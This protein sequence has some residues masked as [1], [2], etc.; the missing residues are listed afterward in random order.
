MID[1]KSPDYREYEVYYLLNFCLLPPVEQLDYFYIK[2]FAPVTLQEHHLG[3][4]IDS[5][6]N[7]KIINPIYQLY[8]SGVYYSGEFISLIWDL[9]GGWSDLY[10]EM[11]VLW[12]ELFAS[13]FRGA[14]FS[15]LERNTSIKGFIGGSHWPEI[16][17]RAKLLLKKADFLDDG[18]VY[19]KPMK[20]VGFH[21]PDDFQ[22][23][24]PYPYWSTCGEFM[25]RADWNRIRDQVFKSYR[26]AEFNFD[27][28]GISLDSMP[29]T[30]A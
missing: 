17:N 20:F 27:S 21:Y 24:D 23:Y 2:N 14:F 25:E 28:A 12:Y 26:G 11:E 7:W 18:M 5:E 4:N 22:V 3:V 16:R 10:E 6:Y 1:R 8:I 19:P 30:D 9:E 15:D 29:E 13:D